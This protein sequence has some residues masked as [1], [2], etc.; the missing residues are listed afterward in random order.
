MIESQGNYKD[1][2]KDGTWIYKYYWYPEVIK[3]QGNYKDGKKNGTW[4]K[5]DEEGRL[6]EETKWENGNKGKTKT[7]W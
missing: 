2:E 3:S 5:Y 1:G 4:K 7:I 6:E